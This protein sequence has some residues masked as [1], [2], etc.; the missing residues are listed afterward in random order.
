MLSSV[1]ATRQV[2]DPSQQD[3]VLVTP[4]LIAV[5][6]GFGE[7]DDVAGAALTAY[8]PGGRGRVR[9]SRPGSR[10]CSAES[11]EVGHH[12]DRRRICTAPTAPDHP[13]RRR[14]R[15]FLVRDGDV[16]QVTHD[17]TV[18]AAMARELA[19]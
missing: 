9:L 14:S 11:A 2:A 4:E 6:D 18:V 13:H 7:R 3:A 17:H 1:S 15:V 8:A 12:P 16:R 10:R 19:S 5:A